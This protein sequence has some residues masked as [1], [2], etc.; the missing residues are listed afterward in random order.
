M[1]TAAPTPEP[2]SEAAGPSDPQISQRPARLGVTIG[3]HSVV[4]FFS[5]LFI[6]IISVLEGRLEMTASQ[7]SIIIGVGGLCSG[8]VQPLVAWLGDRFDTR[9]LGPV[10]FAVTVVVYSLI[11][12]ARSFEDLLVIQIIGTIGIGAFHPAAAAAVGQLAG[13]K[14]SLGVSLFFF[15]GMAGGVSSNMLSPQ[16]AKHFGLENYVWLMIPGLLAVALMIWAIARVPHRH[17]DAHA[18]R[19]SWSAAETRERWVAVWLLY[20]GNVLRF[21]VNMMMVQLVIRWCEGVALGRAG[22]QVLNDAVRVSA[23]TINGPMQGAMQI[24][25]AAGGLSAGAFLRKHHE[26]VALVIVPMAGAVAIV[27]F[28]FAGA[29]A[30]RLGVAGAVSSLAFA[31]AI[32]TGVGYAGTVPVTIALAQRLLPHRTGLASGLMLGGAW[33]FAAAGPPLAQWL[34]ETL[35]L[36]QAFVVTAVLLAVAGLLSLALPGKLLARISPH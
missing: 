7:G 11:G 25:M 30:D 3:T 23:S 21:T 32:A 14:R 1:T 26:K 28:P 2:N 34:N 33:G 13:R 12:Y 29:I 35:G 10:A 24:G 15:A 8:L 22:E 16:L 4:D 31:L 9:L 36:T 19:A 17:H 6:P 18:Q 27:A 5:F 20:I